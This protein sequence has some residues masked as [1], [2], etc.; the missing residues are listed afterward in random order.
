MQHE[1]VVLRWIHKW[2]YLTITVFGIYITCNMCNKYTCSCNYL[3][4]SSEPSQITTLKW[5]LFSV[6]REGSKFEINSSTQRW[7]INYF[8]LYFKSQGTKKN[9][10]I[11][12]CSFT[13]IGLLRWRRDLLQVGLR[14]LR[15]L[16][17]G[18]GR[19]LLR[20]ATL[21]PARDNLRPRTSGLRQTNGKTQMKKQTFK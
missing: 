8:S 13:F 11:N 19:L 18:R 10:E 9:P 17:H 4:L 7:K 12:F 14:G 2:M 6:V 3:L 16:P 1:L 5:L 20:R 21:L 15:L